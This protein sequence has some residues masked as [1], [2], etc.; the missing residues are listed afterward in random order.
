MKT[1]LPSSPLLALPVYHCIQQMKVHDIAFRHPASVTG[2][3]FSTW[4]Q[5]SGPCT[6]TE[7]AFQPEGVTWRLTDHIVPD[8]IEGWVAWPV[9]EG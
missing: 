4:R 8:D 5:Y 9:V 7:E 2:L 1:A 3:R 6:A